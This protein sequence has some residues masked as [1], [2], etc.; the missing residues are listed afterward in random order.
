LAPGFEMTV[1]WY[2]RRIRKVISEITQA[3]VEALPANRKII[4]DFI[5]SWTVRW[6]EDFL[7]GLRDVEQ[8]D[9]T[10]WESDVMFLKFKD[11]V[12][13]NERKLEHNLRG[14]KYYLDETNTLSIVA[15]S[16]RPEKV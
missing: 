5:S 16:G 13:E 3:T 8:W 7:S 14:V 10:D 4:G 11:Y 15:G 2:F 1:Q 9:S 6:I 12:V